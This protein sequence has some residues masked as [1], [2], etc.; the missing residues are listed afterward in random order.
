[1]NLPAVAFFGFL[2]YKGENN[3]Y[4]GAEQMNTNYPVTRGISGYSWAITISLDLI[5]ALFDGF[6]ILSLWGIIVIPAT[7]LALF[8]LCFVG[9]SAV[10]HHHVGETW[11][12]AIKKGLLLGII[13]AIPLPFTLLAFA[14]L[15]GQAGLDR[16]TIYLGQL[17]KAWRELEGI[18][19]RGSTYRMDNQGND[20]VIEYLYANGSLSYAERE[21]LHELRQM[22]NQVVHAAGSVNLPDLINRIQVMSRR[23]RWRLR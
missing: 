1:M 6:S 23:L 16:E 20:F 21:E 4:R 13:A 12:A 10:Q 2:L 14:L 9:V 15:S 5:W 11:E 19:R 18:L 3:L 22:R 17:T 7:M 8:S